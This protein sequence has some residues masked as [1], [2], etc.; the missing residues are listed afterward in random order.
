MSEDRPN[1][2]PATQAGASGE[3]AVVGLEVG[4]LRSGDEVPVIGMERR[5]GTVQVSAEGHGRR[6]RKG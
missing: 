2:Q 1:A 3:A 6:P 5:R 4:V